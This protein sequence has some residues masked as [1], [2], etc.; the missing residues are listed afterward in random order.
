MM[1]N[2]CNVLS[3][4]SIRQKIWISFGSLIGL[5][6]TVGVIAHSSLNAN[7][8]KLSELVN[9]VQPAATLS[10]RLVDQLDR[11]SASLGFYLLS[12][13]DLHKKDYLNYLEK[14]EISAVDL[15]KMKV[16]E[17]N[18][19]TLKLVAEVQEG[20]TKL[21]GF[22]ERMLVYAID[23]NENISAMK[24]AGREVNPRVQQLLTAL[25]QMIMSEQN[26]A[27]SPLR[28]KILLDIY[29]LRTNLA[30][31][32]NE[33]RLYLAF[34]RPE[35][36]N[37]F[38]NF[39]E[40]LEKDV[41]RLNKYTDTQLTFEQDEAR[42][43]FN[44]V[45]PVYFKL[46]RQAM[47]MHGREDWR[48]DAYT[49]RK[50]ISP[51]LVT[52]QDKLNN[53]VESQ[54]K[55]SIAD[56]NVLT[57][58]VRSTQI[59]VASL[60]GFGL[61]AS[62]LVGVLLSRAINNP[63]DELK[64][65]AEELAN[66]NLDR[67]I[68]TA[69]QDELGALARAFAN[70]RDS[71]KRKIED[72]RVLN[73]TGEHLAGLH[74]Q[75]NALQTALKVMGEQT[76]VQWG[77]VYLF[78]KEKNELEVK[79]YYPERDDVDHDNVKTFRLGEGIA[80]KAAKDNKVIYIPDSRLDE[81]F[82]A[83]GHDDEPRAIVCVPM[84]DNGEVFGVMNFT[85]EV[86][87][88][89]FEK[90]DAEFAETISRMT[91]VTYKNI[92]MLNVIE[93]QNRTLEQKVNERTA[94]LAT[95]TN[96]INNMLQNMHQGIFTI[97]K[98]TFV[99]PEYSAYLEKI[100]DTDKIAEEDAIG[101]L[102]SRSD[103]GSNAI[104]Q[105]SA[106]LGAIMGEDSM[107]FDFNKHCFVKEFKKTTKAG[108]EKIL[109]LDWDPIISQQDTIEKVMV[110]VR[111]VTDLRGL[112]AEAEQQKW[113][114]DIIGQ[115][116]AATPKKFEKFVKSAYEY[117]EEN[118]KVID[119][120]KSIDKENISLLFRNMHTIKG[121]ARTYG[122]KYIVDL[123]HDAE[124]TYDH[125]RKDENAEFDKDK[126]V[127]EL[128]GVRDIIE[129][130]NKIYRE[131]LAMDDV[132]GVFLDTELAQ[133]A[134]DA[135]M[136]IDSNNKSSLVNGVNKI[137]NVVKAVGTETL[138]GTLDGLV[139]SIPELAKN[140]HKEVPD[141]HIHDHG[142][143]LN[144]EITN[145][146]KD[147]FTHCLRN[148]LDHGIETAEERLQKDKAPQ[149]SITIDLEQV[150]G[151]VVFSL[152]DDGRGLPLEKIRQKAIDAGIIKKKEKISDKHIAELIFHSGLSTADSVSDVSGRGVGMD[153][154]RKFLQKAGGNIEIELK[155]KPE[156][157]HGFVQFVS[158]ITLPAESYVKVA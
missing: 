58:Q 137:K 33:L 112:Q 20:I 12:K 42:T 117:I 68:D 11:A 94:E 153:A 53:L 22:K 129:T 136:S 27:A 36:I 146:V 54:N 81:N 138:R 17:R 111:D 78:D 19:E 102:F 90:T 25:Q 30:S 103:L 147:V 55:K 64:A 92:Q 145:V 52:I 14:I 65:S 56:S 91:V 32:V 10:L 96:D 126:L 154:V 46:A 3:K 63:I 18:P 133:F 40:L 119:E 135:I 120:M 118:A 67:E 89:K 148:S 87:K 71:I 70:M 69:R 110:T 143:R 106:A 34:R 85:G 47:A 13:E 95:K 93:E 37:N 128:T 15:K 1:S 6:V 114:L 127:S 131:K 151:E 8:K 77:S 99:H 23:Q 155:G 41:A 4:F 86:G 141:V 109:E 123:V 57:D 21:Q 84:A 88:V 75:I 49:I 132:E 43:T 79:A 121:N 115:I 60:I 31:A 76:N 149:G 72:L 66:G 150:A 116:L 61:L 98:E 140:L 83:S 142:I 9:E 51:L 39:V 44:E 80:G 156:G 7:A 38:N 35:V 104:D 45:Y 5:L 97:D 124:S 74:S 62:V 108:N 144:P 113:E 16:V 73:H 130:H 24:L 107:M 139:K 101:M 157:E 158:K 28:R 152:Y 125:M 2:I 82:V 26:E 105:V 59:L 29:S 50:E 100:L 134:M 48:M 122:F